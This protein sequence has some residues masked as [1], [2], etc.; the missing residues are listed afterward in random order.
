MKNLNDVNEL[1]VNYLGKKGAIS[2][3]TTYLKE[4]PNEE[5]KDFV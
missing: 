1:K 2:E 3:L 5:K 4:L